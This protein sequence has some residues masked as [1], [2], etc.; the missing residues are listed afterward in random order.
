MQQQ[1]LRG[2]KH[3]E[4]DVAIIITGPSRSSRSTVAK[5]KTLYYG[6]V[7]E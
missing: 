2:L 3:I 4:I 1:Q 5:C 6:D 7:S